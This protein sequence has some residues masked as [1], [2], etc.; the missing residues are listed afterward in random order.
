MFHFR[1]LL[2]IYILLAAVLLSGCY[3]Y[4]VD[5]LNPDPVTEPESQIAH[6]LFWGLI[7]DP[8]YV[9]AKNCHSNAINDVYISSNYAYAFVTVLSLG[10]WAPVEVEWRCAAQTTDDGHD[11]GML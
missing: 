8:Q 6:S 5:V 7:Q 10:L 1:P 11:S 4:R 2:L 3:G 9:V